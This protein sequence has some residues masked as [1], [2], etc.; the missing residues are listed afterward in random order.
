[1][2]PYLQRMRA[3]DLLAA[4]F[5]AQV[6]CQ[7]NAPLGPIEIPDHPLVRQT[8]RDCLTEAMDV[9]RLRGILERME[10]GDIFCFLSGKD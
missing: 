8:V 5:P 2:Q 6:A 7:D 10:R 4:V 9:E 1:V 3:D